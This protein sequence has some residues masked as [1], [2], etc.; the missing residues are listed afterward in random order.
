MPRREAS[1]TA[2]WSMCSRCVSRAAG[3]PADPPPGVEIICWGG[4]GAHA[5]GARR[6]S[7]LALQV[8]DRF[9]LWQGFDRAVEA[10]SSVGRGATNRPSAG[11]AERKKP[12]ARG[13]ASARRP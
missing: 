6:G 2:A 1:K 3:R 5:A 7:A 11:G 4:A 12:E 10:D 13:G 9:H 8:A